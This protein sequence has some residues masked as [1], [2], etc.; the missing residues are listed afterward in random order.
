MLKPK[1]ILLFKN[2]NSLDQCEKDFKSVNSYVESRYSSKGYFSAP[3]RRGTF[4]STFEREYVRF[5]KFKDNGITYN[6]TTG[7]KQKQG[8]VSLF[9]QV[10]KM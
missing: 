1:A 4:A 8:Y 3:I 6:V 5:G 7:C 9:Y 2:L 10:D